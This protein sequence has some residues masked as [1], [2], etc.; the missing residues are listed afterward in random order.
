[1]RLNNPKGWSTHITL[2]LKAVFSSEGPVAEVGGGVF[3]TPVLHWV[4]KSLGRKL[5]TYENELEYYKF[6]K[7]FQSGMHKIKFLTNWNDMDFKTHWGVV[8]IDHHPPQRRGVDALNFKNTADYIVMHDTVPPDKY[9]WRR[10]LLTFK[11]MYDWKENEN[12]ASVVS[13]FYDVTKWDNNILH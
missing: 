1:M 9:G 7:K 5:I 11:Y 13:N 6:E 4:C 2:L 12:W 10:D 8:F 3:S